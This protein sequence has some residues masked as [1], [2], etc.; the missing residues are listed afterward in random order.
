MKK[1]LLLSLLAAPAA[2]ALT[3]VEKSAS[4]T[5]VTPTNAFSFY[6]TTGITI[7]NYLYTY[8]QGGGA[9]SEDVSCT[10][11]DKIIAYRAPITN[12][13]PGTFERVG[14]ISPCV[15]S[16]TTDSRH[17]DH[18]N[19]PASYGP[20]Q[21]FRATLGGVTKYH[22]MA[23]VSDT[24]NFFNVWRAESP[25]G[26][27]WKWYISDEINNQQFHGKRETIRDL[28][29][30]VTHTIDIVVQAESFIHSNGTVLLNPILLST[31]GGTNNAQWWGFFN[32][33]S[34]T[35]AI[36]QMSVDWDSTGT[37]PTVKMLTNVSGSTY[38]WRTLT[39]TGGAGGSALLDFAPWAHRIPANAKSLINDAATGVY[40]L[41]AGTDRLG[42][43]GANVNCNT[44]T[45][46]LCTT[47]GG[48]ATGDG[49]GCPQGATCNVFLRNTG[50]P[51][52]VMS[53]VGSGF[54]WYPVTRFTFGADNVV[55]SRTRALP[56]GYAEARMFPFRWNS[57]TGR[58]YLFS[59]TND[60][61]ICTQFL[62]SPYLKMYVVRTE[63]GL[64]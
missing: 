19:P 25:D 32:F 5:R 4:L 26:I 39:S 58:R 48:C 43:Y 47:A 18:P 16:P 1:W 61:N 57:P 33:W 50:S 53:G 30:V 2:L 55:Y 10:P 54:V 42:T 21:I 23:D 45:T 56:S 13:V 38:T 44:T 29:D 27:N 40:Q 63:L 12:G 51:G 6:N 7:G 22:L 14:R 28:A 34:G 11:G 46:R 24:L 52:E 59:A 62:F 9:A 8:H 60:A 35:S 20:G 15:K 17:P 64:E 36:G 37:V 31:G 49:S 41:W 3:E